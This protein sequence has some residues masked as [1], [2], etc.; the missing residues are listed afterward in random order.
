MAGP[1]ARG[2]LPNLR[3]ASQSVI[4]SPL[5]LMGPQCRQVVQIPMLSATS[6]TAG[7][8]LLVIWLHIWNC[9]SGLLAEARTAVGERGID[10]FW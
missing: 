5:W 10:V 3:P 6:R 8:L 9:H 7:N 2:S 4:A 1:A